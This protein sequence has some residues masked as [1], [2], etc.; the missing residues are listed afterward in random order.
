MKQVGFGISAVAFAAMMALVSNS[1]KTR[2]TATFFLQVS[3]SFYDYGWIKVSRLYGG[4]WVVE[5]WC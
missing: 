4:A 1:C 5:M 3:Y 2:A